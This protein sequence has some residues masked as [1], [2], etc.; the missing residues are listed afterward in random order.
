[1]ICQYVNEKKRE[2]PK[3]GERNRTKSRKNFHPKNIETN[4]SIISHFIT[5]NYIY[6]A[7]HHN[8]FGFSLDIR[9]IGYLKVK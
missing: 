5:C 7:I 9:L 6:L 4:H 8:S 1:M 2:L 3:S